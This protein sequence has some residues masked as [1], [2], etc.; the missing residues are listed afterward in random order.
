MII[1]IRKILSNFTYASI[2]ITSTVGNLYSSELG[3][4]SCSENNCTYIQITV[5]NFNPNYT[6]YGISNFKFWPLENNDYCTNSFHENSTSG[7]G[8]YRII[9]EY[10]YWRV[11]NIFP[12]GTWQKSAMNKVGYVRKGNGLSPSDSTSPPNEI[13]PFGPPFGCGIFNVNSNAGYPDKCQ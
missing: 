6:G 4:N 8:I 10:Y 12:T 3:L 7:F 9:I 5:E 11:D 13:Y 2:L 1:G